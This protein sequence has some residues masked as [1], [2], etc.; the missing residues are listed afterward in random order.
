[1][2]YSFSARDVEFDATK[3]SACASGTSNEMTA[4]IRKP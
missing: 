1:V 2:L 4:I 3:N